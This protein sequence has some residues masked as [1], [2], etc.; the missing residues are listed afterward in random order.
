MRGLLTRRPQRTRKGIGYWR[1]EI[2]DWRL[3][4]GYWGADCSRQGRKGR[5]GRLVIGDWRLGIGERIAHAKSAK[6]GKEDW[7]LEIG[8]WGLE[9]GDWLLGRGL[10]TLRSQSPDMGRKGGGPRSRD[11]LSRGFGI[12]DVEFFPAVA[13]RAYAR[14]FY[15]LSCLGKD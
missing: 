13:G 14:I 10:L 11:A 9:I 2:G 4:I 6:D 1:L 8:D 3:G 15:V 12:L 7:L 5:K